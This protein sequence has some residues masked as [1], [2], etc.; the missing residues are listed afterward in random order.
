MVSSDPENQYEN[1]KNGEFWY[2]ATEAQQD[3]E[4]SHPFPRVESINEILFQ[5][6]S[7]NG[8]LDSE[9]LG[10]ALSLSSVTEGKKGIKTYSDVLVVDI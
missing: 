3:R 10:A 6:H 5:L 8:M 2:K 7:V 4:Y 1:F 9:K